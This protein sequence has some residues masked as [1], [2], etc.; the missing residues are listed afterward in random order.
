MFSYQL[1]DPQFKSLLWLQKELTMTAKDVNLLA[2]L[3]S[4]G[5]EPQ[6][7]TPFIMER[8]CKNSSHRLPEPSLVKLPMRVKDMA[9]AKVIVEMEDQYVFLPHD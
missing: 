6:N 5:M 1:R 2:S 7:I 9:A 3:G 8:F 4:Y